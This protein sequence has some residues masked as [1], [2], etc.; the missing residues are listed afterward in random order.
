M[1]YIIEELQKD[2]ERWID[3]RTGWN[4]AD[5]I[6]G[7]NLVRKMRAILA[8]QGKGEFRKATKITFV[9]GAPGRPE[10]FLER[11]LVVKNEELYNQFNIAEGKESIDLIRSKNRK[12]IIEIIELKAWE[13]KDTLT[14]A[15]V[16]LLKNF[17]MLEQNLKPSIELLTIAA[18]SQ[19]FKKFLEETQLGNFKKLVN[20]TAQELGV[21]IQLKSIHI[22]SEKIIKAISLS[23]DSNETIDLNTI[24][25][26]GNEISGLDYSKWEC[27]YD[28]S[29]VIDT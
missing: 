25:E 17:L 11:C 12:T 22:T 19:Y 7:K 2:A 8:P 13:S 16:E 23:T 14:H 5:F 29:K 21:P 10:E 18:P 24:K 27:I 20:E 6:T 1:T 3:T 9:K 15:L 4:N 26:N 28:T